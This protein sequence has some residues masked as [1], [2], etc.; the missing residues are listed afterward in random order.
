MFDMLSSSVVAFGAI[1]T[2]E[3][4]TT[5]EARGEARGDRGCDADNGEVTP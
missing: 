5:H 2:V 4:R 3:E 1:N